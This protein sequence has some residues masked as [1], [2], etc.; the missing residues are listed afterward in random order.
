MPYCD[1]WRNFFEKGDGFS[2]LLSRFVFFTKQ[3][4]PSA[5]NKLFFFGFRSLKR[6]LK[7]RQ[8][9]LHCRNSEQFSSLFSHV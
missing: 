9:A 5:P 2:F 7:T 1:W 4:V 3:Y 8:R 6:V